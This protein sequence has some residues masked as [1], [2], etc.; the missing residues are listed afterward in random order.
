M[1]SH[2]RPLISCDKCRSP[3]VF[4]Q[5]ATQGVL[6]TLIYKCTV[7]KDRWALVTLHLRETDGVKR[8]RYTE[9]VGIFAGEIAHSVGELISSGIR[10]FLESRR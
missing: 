7:C 3:M 10:S 6:E 4:S 1:A 9:G 2:R 8:V 5:E